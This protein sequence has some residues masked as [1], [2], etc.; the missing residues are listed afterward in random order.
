MNEAEEKATQSANQTELLERLAQPEVR[1]ALD[2]LIDHLPQL[3]EMAAQLTQTYALI[4]NV[5]TDP[6]FAADLKGGIDEFFGPV[7]ERAKDIA[8]AVIEANDRAREETGMIG[9]LG[10]LR[11]MKDPQT[12]KAFRFAKALLE[13][14]NDRETGRFKA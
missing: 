14:L 4:R 2:S 10:L 1:Q 12:Q 8:S 3:T 13:I 7:K 9:L 6:V 5:A 11:M